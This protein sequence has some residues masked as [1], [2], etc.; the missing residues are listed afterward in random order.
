[1]VHVAYYSYVIYSIEI[2]L[3]GPAAIVC[4]CA[5]IL[6]VRLIGVTAE[7]K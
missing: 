5:I 7:Y 6:D 3:P 4:P 1:M 2:Y